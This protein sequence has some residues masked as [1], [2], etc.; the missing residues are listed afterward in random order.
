MILLI[1]EEL[2]V[3]TNNEPNL[4]V[5]AIHLQMLTMLF[6]VCFVAGC[7]PIKKLEVWKDEAYTQPLQK[8]LVIAL[9]Q[10]A[11]IRRQFENVLSN[12]LVKRGVEAIPSYKVLPQSDEALDREMVLAKVRDLGIDSVL[13]ARSIS[14]KEVTNH[15]HGGVNMG[16]S[17]VSANDAWYGYSYGYVNN[18]Q[19]DTNYLTISTKLYDV[20]SNNPA[21]SYISQVRV[22]G[23]REAAVNL[24]VPTV[25]QQLVDSKLLEQK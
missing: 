5:R 12:Q 1:Q 19:Y 9:T 25:V 10:Q 22:S 21:W 23:S 13:V 3:I 15:Q 6:L 4:R 7:A 8:V 16:G 24:L 18:R 14:R 20:A 11:H 17:A 2:M